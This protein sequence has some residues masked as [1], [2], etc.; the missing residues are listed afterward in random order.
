[1][2][3][4][5][6]RPTSSLS[7]LEKK[8]SDLPEVKVDEVLSFVC[9]ITPKVPADNAVPR[10]VVLLVEF[11]LDEGSNVLLDVVFL[12]GLGSAVD[13][14]LLHVLRHVRILNNSLSLCHI[15][16]WLCCAVC[17]VNSKKKSE[18]K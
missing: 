15:V 2:L 16:L 8:N 7:A 9:N 11:L 18:R 14:V 5:C 4:T 6:M 1:M 10:G 13:G 12:E 17:R 3:L